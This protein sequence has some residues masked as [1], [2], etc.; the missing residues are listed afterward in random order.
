[1][2]ATGLQQ[3]QREATN[4]S[5]FFFN[6]QKANKHEESRLLRPTRLNEI[7]LFSF[8]FFNFQKANNHEEPRLLRP[9]RLNE[10]KGIK[11]EAEEEIVYKTTKQWE[12]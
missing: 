6:F 8:F 3:V 12:E 7:K 4:Q 1:M 2:K 11:E 9:A 5:F 10:S